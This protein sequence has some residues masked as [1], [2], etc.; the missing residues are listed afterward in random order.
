MVVEDFHQDFNDLPASAINSFNVLWQNTQLARGDCRIVVTAY[1]DGKTATKSFPEIIA[2]P[3]FNEDGQVNFDDF[4]VLAQFWQL[5]YSLA[6][7]APPGGDCIIDYYDLQA[8][9]ENWLTSP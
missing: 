4:A 3:D 5:N 7:I 9:L 8:M 2:S 6:D 1:Y